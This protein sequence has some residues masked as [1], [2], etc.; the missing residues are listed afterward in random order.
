M[1]AASD[2]IDGVVDWLIGGVH[3]AATPDAVLG[4]MCERV[5]ACGIPVWRAAAFIRTL[6]PEIMGRRIEWRE[7]AG[8]SVG[9][10]S[11][12][13]FDSDAFRDSPVSQVYREGRVLRVRLDNL[14]TGEFPQLDDLRAEGATDYL[15][16][17]F[18]FSNGEIHVGTWATRAPGGFTEAQIAAL[19][20]LTEPL[21]RIAEIRALRRTAVNLLDTYVGNEAGARIL[22]GQIRLGFTETI[23]AVIWLSDMRGFTALADSIEP[24]AL[25][26]L[27]N[28]YFACQVPAIAAHGGEVLKFMGDGLLAIFPLTDGVDAA[29]VC[30]AA[31]AAAAE[32]RAAIAALAD[33]PILG[34]AGGPRFGLALH[35]GELLYGNIGAGNRLDFTCIGPAVNLAA[36]LEGLASRLGRTTLLSA[37]FVERS[38]T[39]A[40]K[41]GDFAL[42]GFRDMVPVFGLIDD[43]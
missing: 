36:R 33:W 22:A 14:A 20:R 15:A 40:E 30:Q 17:P 11:F 34:G 27:L 7:G 4:E 41:L 29:D 32:T 5:V 19:R 13:I 2:G 18:H 28:R 24:T 6:H 43:D 21:A 9:E 35:V 8:T 26:A 31:L 12:A 1:L 37:A 3:S 10:A 39:G 42:A 38:C 25:I 16:V 23:R